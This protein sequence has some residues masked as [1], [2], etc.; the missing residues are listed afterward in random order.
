MLLDWFVI[1]LIDDCYLRLALGTLWKE[2]LYAKFSKCALCLAQVSFW[3]HLVS[4]DGIS[5]D[6]H[7]VDIVTRWERPKVKSFLGL[8]GYMWFMESFLKIVMPLICLTRKG[9]NFIWHE[10]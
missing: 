8:I 1:I 6:P 2:K 4:R 3:M 10:A 9:V 7:M 5:I